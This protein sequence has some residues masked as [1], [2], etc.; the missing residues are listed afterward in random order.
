MKKIATVFLL[1]F[2]MAVKAY[3]YQCEVLEVVGAATVHH[4][5][6]E[7]APLAKGDLL[8]DGDK[9]ETAD[10]AT[11][12]LSFDGQWNNTVRVESATTVR[13]EEVFPTQINLD[14]GSLYAKLKKL[15]VGSQFEIQMPVAVAAAR[16]TEFR[17]SYRDGQAGIFNFSDSKVYVYTVSQAGGR[18]EVPQLLAHAQKISLVSSATP[19]TPA[20]EPMSSEEKAAGK[21]L[22]QGIETAVN[23]AVNEGRTSPIQTVEMLEEESVPETTEPET[24]P[25]EEK[26]EDEDWNRTDFGSFAADISLTGA[27]G[28][29]SARFYAS[30]GGKSRVETGE[31]ISIIR[32]DRGIVWVLIPSQNMY[33]EQPLNQDMAAQTSMSGGGLQSHRLIGEETIDG[34][35][36]K[37]YEVVL[38]TGSET[39][40]VYQWMVKGVAVPARMQAQDGSWTVEYKNVDMRAQPAELFEVPAGYQKMDMGALPQN[41]NDLAAFQKQ[42]EDQNQ[43]K[44]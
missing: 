33:L 8:S 27:Q 19:S 4:S 7:S 44:K 15:P 43:G 12:D 9:I 28:A 36:A 20:V 16:G 18:S 31:N 30:S 6:G 2:F 21:E 38:S 41:S 32:T 17:T 24:K 22:A 10:D 1:A 11:V 26:E 14:A 13:V 29:F 37:K 35:P 23:Q 3:A 39:Q 42:L 40:T 34:K 5:S 25:K